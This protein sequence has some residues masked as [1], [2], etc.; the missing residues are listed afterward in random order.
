MGRS[1]RIQPGCVGQV[2]QAV[3]RHGFARQQDLAEALGLA[4]STVCNF[5]NGK[6]V[7][8]LNFFELSQTLGF[9]LDA[10]ANFEPADSER[11][12]CEIET[13]RTVPAAVLTAA[14]V[15][16]NGGFQT[17]LEP[18]ITHYIERP[19]IESQCQKTLLLPG[20]LIRIKAPKRMGKT[21]LMAHL[22]QQVAR[23]GCL[24]VLLNLQLADGTILQ[25]LRLFL[26][27]FCSFVAQRVGLPPQLEAYW[28]EGLGSN[29]T[30]TC[31]FEEYL[32]RNIEQPLVLCLDD[33]DRLFGCGAIAP[34]FLGL[35]RAWHDEAKFHPIWQKL[36]LV[37]S[38]STEVYLSLDI[39][40]SPFNVGLPIELPEFNPRFII[41]VDE[42]DSVLSLSFDL[43]DFF[44]L[45]RACFNRRSEK[46]AFERLTFALFG[47]AT[48]SD[49]I[50]DPVR[51]PFNV[52]RAIALHGFQYAEID[53][54][55]PGLEGLVPDPAATLEQVLSWTG[56]QPFLTQNT[57]S[58][59]PGR[60]CRV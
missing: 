13:N 35:L 29:Y 1:L 40:R 58:A 6:P 57:L 16:L 60:N 12:N 14:E 30:C 51:T 38:H 10:I 21:A 42:I 22:L 49:L 55:I 46:P 43:D 32:L 54:L 27:W 28:E 5:L 34:D 37:L 19:P 48:P 2:K 9:E 20:S 17:A 56:G 23:Q 31:Y 47:V 50:R 59:H 53:P 26:R 24:P 18:E 41:F 33:V 52:G 36:R 25:N 39:N 7:D 44:A 8:Y 15:T 45:I 11:A 3:R 4:R